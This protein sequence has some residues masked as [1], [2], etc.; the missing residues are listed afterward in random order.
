[1][2]LISDV[3]SVQGSGPQGGDS[4]LLQQAVK[5]EDSAL[6]SCVCR[7]VCGAGEGNMSAYMT[8]RLKAWYRE[9]GLSLCGGGCKGFRL[10]KALALCLKNAG[11]EVGE[12]A[13]KKALS[14]GISLTG[15]LIWGSRFWLFHAGET[16]AYVLNHYFGHPHIRQ[17]TQDRRPGSGKASLDREEKIFRGNDMCVGIRSGSLQSGVGIL[18]CTEGLYG[19]VPP[20]LIR[21]CLDPGEIYREQQIGR[22]LGELAGE[23]LRKGCDDDI[24]AVYIRC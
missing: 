19:A 21:Q 11:K 4:V 6:L 17:L 12:F 20:S 14:L 18:I 1:M 3:I 24:S 5:G 13:E 16:R 23:A 10:E 8:G 7:T 15:V 22:R 2:K 9:T